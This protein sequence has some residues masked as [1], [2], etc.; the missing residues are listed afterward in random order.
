[1]TSAVTLAGGVT[2]VLALT[3]AVHASV[4]RRGLAALWA[5]LKRDGIAALSYPMRV[6]MIVVNVVIFGGILLFLIGGWLAPILGPVVSGR[7]RDLVLHLFVGVVTWPAVWSG[8]TATS[9]SLRREQVLGTLEVLASTPVGLNAIPFASFIRR[10]LLA[11][12]AGAGIFT[13]VSLLTPLPSPYLLGLPVVLAALIMGGLTLWGLG[14]VFGALTLLYKDLGG[15]TNMIQLILLGLSG[16]YFPLALLPIPFELMGQMFPVSLAF[17]LT[18]AGLFAPLPTSFALPRLG[19]LMGSAIIS[20]QLGTAVF[21][22]GL[23]R[24]RRQ[25]QIQGY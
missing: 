1:M 16:A 6:V 10:S 15:A 9:E 21:R 5:H 2:G 11:I 19:I 24:A 3:V 17:D 8:F 12:A 18:R 7:G 25:G 4:G 14:L 13:A 22:W 23:D 20:I